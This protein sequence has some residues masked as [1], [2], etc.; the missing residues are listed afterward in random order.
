LW[1]VGARDRKVERSTTEIRLDQ[2]NFPEIEALPWRV[3]RREQSE[4]ADHAQSIRPIARCSALRHTDNEEE[5]E[6]DQK[7]LPAT[8]PPPH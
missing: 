6:D 7:D 3:E 4:H 1:P 5:S 2:K 8:G